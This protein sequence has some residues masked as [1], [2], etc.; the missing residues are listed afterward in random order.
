MNKVYKVIWNKAKHCYV[1]V[2]ELA[3]SQG[4]SSQDKRASRLSMRVA[5]VLAA[6]LVSI[7]GGTINLVQAADAPAAQAQ[8]ITEKVDTN[9]KVTVD[10]T[11]AGGPI[12]TVEDIQQ[13]SALENA[14]IV[15]GNVNGAKNSIALGSGSNAYK[16]NSTAIGSGAKSG[17]L[18][19]AIGQDA[20]KA[21]TGRQGAITV[22]AQSDTKGLYSV[23]VGTKSHLTSDDNQ[24]VFTKDV[25][26]AAAT[27]IGSFNNLS[28]KATEGKAFASVGNTV[29]GAGNTTED[30]NGV[31]IQGV[32]NKVTNS[33]KNI[34]LNLLDALKIAGGDFSA[35]TDKETG[36]IAVIGGANT[37]DASHAITN[38]GFGANISKSDGVFV[39]GQ[40][41]VLTG[42][43]DSLIMG[44]NV[45]LKGIKGAI[46]LGDKNDITGENAVA[47]GHE[48][49]VKGN[50]VVAIGQ[51]NKVNNA[52]GSIA[53]GTNA[54]VDM[55]NLKPS[56][57]ATGP[58]NGV[59]IGTDTVVKDSAN[60]IAIGA[61]A[62]STNSNHSIAIGEGSS[63]SGVAETENSKIGGISQNN[64]AIGQNAKVIESTYSNSEDST[65]IGA[66][67]KLSGSSKSVALGSGANITNGYQSIAI[68]NMS[69]VEEGGFNGTALGASSIVKGGIA[70]SVALGSNS[71]AM[72]NDV[73]SV[74]SSKADV[75]KYNAYVDEY[76]ATMA[77]RHPGETD[78]LLQK[79]DESSVKDYYRRVTNVADGVEAHD[80]VTLGQLE[81]GFV[82]YDKA[83]GKIDKGAVT[84]A[85]DKGTSLNNVG[86]ITMK[87]PY[88]DK[89][90][91]YQTVYKELS[92][93]KA[94]LIPGEVVFDDNFKEDAGN[95]IVKGNVV[96]IGGNTKST[97]SSGS[98]VLGAFGSIE[99]SNFATALGTG[100]TITDGNESTAIGNNASVFHSDWSTAIGKNASITGIWDSTNKKY[101]NVRE[102]TAIGQFAGVDGANSSVALGAYSKV[103]KGQDKVVSVGASWLQRKIINVAD[104]SADSDAAT[105]GQVTKSTDGVKALVG[106]A[107]FSR[108]NYAKGSENVTQAIYNVD[109]QV[110]ANAEG[111][112]KWEKG[113]DKDGKEIYKP[114]YIANE[115]SRLVLEKNYAGLTDG[116]TNILVQDGIVST[117]GKLVAPSANLGTDDNVRLTVDEKG[118]VA[119]YQKQ[120][121][122]ENATWGTTTQQLTLDKDNGLSILSE[123]TSTTN[124]NR[125]SQKLDFASDKG[126][127][128]TENTKDKDE[129]ISKST[130]IKGNT[131]RD[132][133]GNFTIGG[134]NGGMSVSGAYP[135]GEK[136]NLSVGGNSITL[137][138]KKDKTGRVYVSTDKAELTYGAGNTGDSKITADTDSVT[139]GKSNSTV[140]TNSQGTTFTNK[141]KKQTWTGTVDNGTTN[142]NGET[143]TLTAKET[144][145]P[146]SSTVVK[147]TTQA[148]IDSTGVVLTDSANKDVTTSLTTTGLN[149][150]G[151]VKAGGIT[152]NNSGKITG[153]AAGTEAT[154]AVNKGQLDEAVKN[155]VSGVDASAV[156]YDT[157]TVDGKDVI[158]KT[159]VTFNPGGT[160]TTLKNINDIQAKSATFS[161][162]ANKDG[163]NVGTTFNADGTFTNTVAAGKSSATAVNKLS[164]DNGEGHWASS[165]DDGKYAFKD[166]AG[167]YVFE[168]T[169][170]LNGRTQNSALQIQGGQVSGKSA[171]IIG[172]SDNRKISYDYQLGSYSNGQFKYATKEQNTV[173][174]DDKKKTFTYTSQLLQDTKQI[175]GEVNSDNYTSDN[176]NLKAGFRIASGVSLD[177]GKYIGPV[178]ELK[179]SGN[180]LQLRSNQAELAGTYA[181]KILVDEAGTTITNKPKVNEK[182]V[183][184]GSTNINGA[185]VTLKQGVL[186]DNSTQG[187]HQAVIDSTGVVLTDSAKKDVT[188]SL[189]TTGL[190]TTGTVKAGDIT[191]TAADGKITGLN[192]GAIA[193]DSK[194]AVNGSQ[195]YAEQDAREK[196]DKTFADKFTA[197]ED[198]GIVAGTNNGESSNIVLGTG[199]V[200]GSNVNNAVVVGRNADVSAKYGT[201]L[202]DSAK[203]Y[204]V[205]SVA[206]GADSIAS[207]NN[208]VSVG[209][210]GQERKIVNVAAGTADTDAVNYGQLKKVS[211]VASAGFTVEFAQPDGSFQK[212]E[213]KPGDTV[214][215]TGNN[216]N[217]LA[218]VDDKGQVNVSLND[219]LK[220]N[221]VAS[222]NGQN[223]VALTDT[224]VTVATTKGTQLDVTGDT[225][226]ASGVKLQNGMI[227][228]AVKPMFGDTQTLKFN[229]NG[230]TVGTTSNFGGGDS[231]TS[232]KGNTIKATDSNDHYT[233][234]KGGTVRTENLSVYA[235]N[236][237]TLKFNGTGLNINS[238]DANVQVGKD[239]F[240]DSD[241]ISMSVDDGAGHNSSAK[242][243]KGGT[244][245]SYSETGASGATTTT[246]KGDTI[247]TGTI[248]AG[249]VVVNA[250][251]SGKITN[252]K[253]G[254]ADT[255][256][257]NVKQLKDSVG[258]ATEGVV[259]WDKVNDKYVEGRLK[260][261]TFNGNGSLTAGGLTLDKNAVSAGESSL[262]IDDN[263]ATLASGDSN[264]IVTKNQ[265]KIT[266]P[267]EDAISL[268][269]NGAQFTD[270]KTTTT[271]K[272]DALT[273]GSVTAN[274]GKIGNVTINNGVFYQ[275]TALRDGSLFLGGNTRDNTVVS[276]LG[277]SVNGKKYVTKDG[278]NANDQKVTNVADG[279]TAKDAVN[280]GQLQEVKETA[281][282]GFSVAIQQPDGTYNKHTY[283][284]GD[285]VTVNGKNANIL[286][287]V[288]DKGVVNVSLNDS[289]KLGD[290]KNP[291]VA[292][293]GNEGTLAVKNANG[294]LSV[295]KEG[296]VSAWS[297]TNGVS[298]STLGTT[299]AGDVTVLNENAGLKVTKDLINAT[300]DDAYLT[301]GKN[302][303]GLGYG[304]NNIHVNDQG[305]YVSGKFNA[306]AGGNVGGVKFTG[307]NEDGL[308]KVTNVAAGVADTDAATVG[309]LNKATASSKTEV[310][311]ADGETN[312][313]VEKTTGANGQDIYSVALQKQLDLTTAGSVSFGKGNSLSAAGLTIN[314]NT[315]I[316]KEGINANSQKITN[317]AAGEASTDAVNKGQLDAVENKVTGLDNSAVKWDDAT[318]KD[319]INGVGLKDGNVTANSVTAKD[320]N[321]ESLKVNGKDV[322]TQ[323]YVDGAVDKVAG[324]VTDLKGKVETNTKDI[325]TN[326]ADIAQNKA[327]IAANKANIGDVT[328]YKDAG[329]NDTDGKAVTNVVDATISN[330]QAITAVDTKV[331]DGKLDSGAS[332]LT[333][334]INQNYQAIQDNSKAIGVLGGAV[335]KL[336]TRVDRVGAGAAALAALHP[337]DY[338][339]A[340]KWDFAAGYGHYK[341]AN[342]VSIGTYYRPN[343]TTLFSVG[344]SFGGGE[345][346]VNAGVSFKLGSGNSG[347]S[348][349]RTAM[350]AEIDTLK[351]HNKDL[352]D[353]VAAQDKKVQELEKLVQ[354]LIKNQ[355]ADK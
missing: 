116:Q 87:V 338:D 301:V 261:V 142:I 211:D 299:V 56:A 340:N 54:S 163:V 315:Y 275:N 57:P 152:I 59:A 290:Q 191:L 336:D 143:I 257:V 248:T 35:L 323:D 77:K 218:K 195:L 219:D 324:D 184:T 342:A 291:G 96:A 78:R 90:N 22:G 20:G 88:Q 271:I 156:K 2:S 144:Q 303:A 164:V 239:F 121:N 308:G 273:T 43:E 169:R 259:K 71:I 189:T 162:G 61:R 119:K 200:V 210:N 345:N 297:G 104:G 272:G 69:A 103:E 151:T 332:N 306:T 176:Y 9:G 281:N 188:T 16:G 328:K 205:N 216:E 44:N 47:I 316:T 154:D 58:W 318:K 165:A 296:T 67:V 207:E 21:S 30:S 294:G 333:E 246:I 109:A 174:V 220:V 27:V 287:G 309:Q 89:A 167:G 170:T 319:S 28:T 223:K 131:I 146:N 260:G 25:Q 215:V 161:G 277:L 55:S 355:K 268:G 187:T 73:I 284:P 186:E 252:L 192:G 185:I 352:E 196:A 229:E 339:P 133:E 266:T 288:D 327:D 305:T 75:K 175:T 34:D 270:G 322:A 18:G 242:L 250:D 6:F 108:T 234:I 37:I 341:G 129:V 19:V 247:K 351:S 1:V 76:N 243:T 13:K 349:S 217:I 124:S 233:E 92:F 321:F 111:V 83:D 29:F 15:P 258:T 263:Q 159:S 84:F 23:V 335:N 293:D 221:S 127:V 251:N 46:S 145:E 31:I 41:N 230:L 334:G 140:V 148:I 265:V 95:S 153:V 214:T 39:A 313:T 81:N 213:V 48:N 344:G 106:T 310:K 72:E 177:G 285:T 155:G 126:L 66:N 269:T 235:D 241:M 114:G 14:G 115:N 325:A 350:A 130:I 63:A 279:T 113:T 199:A 302:G 82:A 17:E 244:V 134:T 132:S 278:L 45:N 100:A 120:N 298:V 110:K 262:Y 94:G 137:E 117:N 147:G 52:S 68:G 348:T 253:A 107:D 311:A 141:R 238:G 202:G 353:K 198:A 49:K 102:N 62:D 267:G 232:I 181:S 280:Y 122:P 307:V 86:D 4:K 337:L 65:A 123:N 112:V 10:T 190:T 320:G 135:N 226:T 160:A 346:M 101:V 249:K 292:L 286:A 314:N 5:A 32:G 33:Y 228:T 136:T 225:V 183:S 222:K 150:T 8:T 50:N 118:L 283:K 331:G 264:V 178:A 3:K 91:G 204:G 274:S 166:P 312:I 157:K 282:K 60:G 125:G 173:T 179:A 203:V 11:K 201:A 329:I 42:V 53:L 172:N 206:L 193:E 171:Q 231:T 85:G 64:T 347:V 255:D 98:T 180:Y 276:N 97:N 36:S 128:I 194:E 236:D 51:K 70:D 343:E 304:D 99:N 168:N 105:V 26:G 158:D 300:A 295:T 138:A 224:G 227:S 93:Q 208:V 256:A 197:Y 212:K 330:K 317:V 289:I 182:R 7:G 354:E 245:F 254:S 74:G 40:H 24:K 326:K 149:T 237:N 79:I 240:S 209:S 38:I 80:A 139:I 12:V